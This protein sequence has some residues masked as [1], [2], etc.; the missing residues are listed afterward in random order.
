[1][2]SATTNYPQ[3]VLARFRLFATD[4]TGATERAATTRWTGRTRRVYIRPVGNH[5]VRSKRS[6]T[7]KKKNPVRQQ[8]NRA[9]LRTAPYDGRRQR[10]R[11]AKHRVFRGK[12][13]FFRFRFFRFRL[14][15]LSTRLLLPPLS[16][17]TVRNRRNVTCRRGRSGR[18][19]GNARSR[20]IIV[21]RVSGDRLQTSVVVLRLFSRRRGTPI[22]YDFF[23]TR[24]P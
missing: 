19:T 11:V 15:L 8:L 14:F 9:A 5:V 21:T 13:V 22:E 7:K 1:M 23:A 10:V 2:F 18:T 4:C 6:R 16:F 17:R 3:S 20:A 12:S 24:S